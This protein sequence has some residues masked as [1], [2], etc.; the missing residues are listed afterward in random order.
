MEP[1]STS[2]ERTATWSGGRATH[3]ELNF[4]RSKYGQRVIIMNWLDKD[5]LEIRAVQGD[6]RT[7]KF[8]VFATI[9]TR[10]VGDWRREAARI[11]R[12][13]ADE[14]FA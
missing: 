6:G 8:R 9:E 5:L 10:P 1:I 2:K 12:S 13:L 11:A 7:D 3:F 4:Q 14:H